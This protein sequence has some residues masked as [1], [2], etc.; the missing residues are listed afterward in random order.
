MGEQD[1]PGT[2]V[3]RIKEKTIASL[4]KE[5]EQGAVMNHAF[6]DRFVRSQSGGAMKV[7]LRGDGKHHL[8][9]ELHSEKLDTTVKVAAGQVVQVDIGNKG[10][11]PY[12]LQTEW[13]GI[14]AQFNTMTNF[15]GRLMYNRQLTKERVQDDNIYARGCEPE[16]KKPNRMQ[17]SQSMQ[18]V[19]QYLPHEGGEDERK[20]VARK[21][22]GCKHIV[23]PKPDQIH[24]IVYGDNIPV[25][26]LK[27]YTDIGHNRRTTHHF[28]YDGGIM[29]M[30]PD[31]S[32]KEEKIE[33][34]DRAVRKPGVCNSRNGYSEFTVWK[35]SKLDV[36]RY[37]QEV[38]RPFKRCLSEPPSQ[39]ACDTT[40]HFENGEG[41]TS[42]SG[43]KPPRP[44]PH[45][46][47]SPD[48]MDVSLKHFTPEEVAIQ[49]EMRL[50]EDG[51][52]FDKCKKLAETH[53]V[54][55]EVVTSNKKVVHHL[56][57]AGVADILKWN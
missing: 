37:D 25:R 24:P 26:T 56:G 33:F 40:T 35:N 36:G 55:R 18:A 43:R 20:S 1:D 16:D 28:T 11:P 51:K 3:V 57:S 42:D 34:F 10:T 46:T 12:L 41:V 44:Q 21:E 39:V 52:F 32:M 30:N 47:C 53:G 17:R 45:L 13:K 23:Q 8:E 7:L 5:A 4:E 15:S 9:P 38:H 22:L 2:T 31:K 6:T 19:L 48:G 49:R 29:Q 14:L 27:D 54:M 50:A